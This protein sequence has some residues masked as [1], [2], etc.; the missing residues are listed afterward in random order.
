MNN[1]TQDDIIIDEYNNWFNFYFKLPLILTILIGVACFVLGIV[2]ADLFDGAIIVFWLVGAV[3][4]ALTYFITKISLSAIILNIY[5]LKSIDA[6][7]SR[8]TV[9]TPSILKKQATTATNANK[10]VEA[11]WTCKKCGTKNHTSAMY[12]LNC[13]ASKLSEPTTGPMWTCPKCGE[14]NKFAAKNCIN[15]FE[16]KP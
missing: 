14:K 4:S 16:P 10:A 13:R 15:C 12:C 7:L 6:K 1:Y 3:V 9:Y 5:Y 2:F 8:E 11:T